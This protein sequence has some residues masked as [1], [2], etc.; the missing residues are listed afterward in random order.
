LVPETKPYHESTET[1]ARLIKCPLVPEE[2]RAYWQNSAR[3]VETPNSTIAFEQYWFGAKSLPRVKV[4]LLN[5]QTRFDTFPESLRVLQGWDVMMPDTRTAICHWHMQLTDPLYRAFTGD[6]LLSRGELASPDI[7]ASSVVSW[8]N[9]NGQS[10][11]NLATKKNLASRL[12]SVASSAGLVAGRRDPRTPT[13]PRVTDE[14]LTYILYL[15]RAVNYSG[16]ALSNPYLRSVG[17]TGPAL[18][19]SSCGLGRSRAQHQ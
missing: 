3:A 13:F 15:L 5:L 2:S 18:E 16:T 17:L 9:E 1:H 4:L 8:V 19:A 7:H 10:T 14:A 12:I 11:W 6:Y